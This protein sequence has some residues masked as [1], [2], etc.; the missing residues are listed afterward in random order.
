MRE[1]GKYLVYALCLLAGY[2]WTALFALPLVSIGFVVRLLVKLFLKSTVHGKRWRLMSSTDAEFC[3]PSMDLREN[4]PIVSTFIEF[5]GAIDVPVFVRKFGALLAGACASVRSS[6]S[7][8]GDGEGLPPQ[9]RCPETREVL[10][11]IVSYPVRKFGFYFWKHD[12]EFDMKRHVPDVKRLE[13]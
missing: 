9:L 4:P 5:D 1:C 6:A 7:A 12:E 10:L 8:G 11:K 3:L 2:L 13:P